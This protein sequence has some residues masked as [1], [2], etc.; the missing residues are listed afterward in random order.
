MSDPARA[1][2]SPS[3]TVEIII[4]MAFMAVGY[5][6][7]FAWDFAVRRRQARAVGVLRR[8]ARPRALPAALDEDERRRRIPNEGLREFVD[9]TRLSFVELDGLIDSFDLLQLRARDQARFGVVTIASEQRRARAMALLEGWLSAWAKVDEQTH[10][11]LR[12]LALG[13][14]T[15]ADVI[16]RE[17]E[18]VSW[19]FR[20][21]T[22]RGLSETITDLDRAVIHMQ[23]V[24]AQLERE[25]DDPYR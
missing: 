12:A 9:L 23:G 24:V 11:Q 20:R 16:A 3:L 4:L 10:A 15:I 1:Q 5:T 19:E 14:E 22:E 18:R 2:D 21:D 7:N 13:P 25:V 6:I 8:H 17:R